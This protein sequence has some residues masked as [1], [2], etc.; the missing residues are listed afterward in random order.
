[1]PGLGESKQ[2]SKTS[3]ATDAYGPAKGTI[4]TLLGQVNGLTGST[5]LNANESGAIDN[6]A[7]TG[8]AGN[9]FAGAIS[10][11]A[12]GLLSGGGAQGNDTAISGNL[13][14]YK[15]LLSPWAS[16][17]NIGNNTALKTQ[18]DTMLNDTMNS[19][20]GQFAASGRDITGNA[21][22]GQAIARGFAAGAAP[23]V[24]AQYNADAD[25]AVNAASSLYNAGNSTY[26][27]LNQNNQQANANKTAGVDVGNA[28]LDAKNWG[29]NTVLNAEAARRSIPLNNIQTLLGMALPAG[30][31]FGTTNGTSETTSTMSPIQMMTSMISALQP[32]NPIKIG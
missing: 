24:A 1:M 27:L 17:S 5:G 4:D 16:G 10:D 18:L 14:D 31:A 9:P 29:D 28:A 2:E 11:A 22:G 32:K 26:G 7:A 15:T 23:T 8:K 30:Q 19:Y 3:Q 25:R 20:G 12:T 6:L 13:A 21:A